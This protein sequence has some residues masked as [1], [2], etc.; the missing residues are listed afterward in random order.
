MTVGSE[1]RKDLHNYLSRAHHNGK[2]NIFSVTIFAVLMKI[3][4]GWK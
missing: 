1:Q 3:T 2:S 4:V